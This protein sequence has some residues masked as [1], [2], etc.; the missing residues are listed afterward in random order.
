MTLYCGVDFHARVQ[1]VCYCDMSEGEIHVRELHHLKDDVRG[2]YAQFHGEVIVG[3]EASGYSTWFEAMLE[4]LGH[5][6]WLGNTVEIRKRARRRQ[7]TDRRDA[8][9]I[10]DLLLKEEFPRVHRPSASSR[11]VLQMLR[12]R[13]RLVRMR[14]MVKNSLQ[15]LAINAG[16]A[17]KSQL[18]TRGGRQR[19]REAPLSGSMA[20]QREQWLSLL[21][22]LEQRVEPLNDWLQ[23]KAASDARVV[24][25]RTQPGIGLLTSLGL[26][27]TLEPVTRFSNSR[28]VVAYV[29]LDPV[30]RSSAERKRFQGI[31]KE[32]S[33]LMR[34]F[35]GEAA[36]LASRF[37]P[38]LKRFY[39]RLAYRRGPQKAKVAVARKLLVRSFIMLR[40]AV[41]YAEFHRR[42]VEVRPARKAQ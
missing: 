37:D 19:L 2:F 41:D 20:E 16:L 7:K 18:L 32:G 30:E 31:S 13:H 38:E 5:Q 34:F 28:K 9:L 36:H 14:T 29:G 26:V 6:V 40:D 8:E 22:E 33:P 24:R 25:L 4:E 1:T 3:I 17:L 23:Q 39:L 10:L 42:G 27:H 21:E 35:L 11:E 12:Y 15:A